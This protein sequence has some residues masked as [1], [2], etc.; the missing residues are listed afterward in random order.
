MA[1]FAELDEDNKVLRVIVVNNEDITVDG[2]ESET[3]GIE[4]CKK[5]FGQD[6][7]WLQTSYNGNTRKKYAGV[8]DTYD[9]LKDVFISPQPYESWSLDENNDWQAPKP[10]PDEGMWVWDEA[11]LD[12]LEEQL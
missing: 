7:N 5:L 12:W 6:T 3:K 8:G 4:F 10:M 9:E 11:T 1:H 2:V